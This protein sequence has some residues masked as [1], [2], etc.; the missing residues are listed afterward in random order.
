MKFAGE[1][2]RL[3]ASDVANFVACQHMTRLDL[4]EARGRLHRPRRFDVGFEDLVQRGEEHERI[5]LEQFRADGCQVVDMNPSPSAET[6]AAQATREAIRGGADVI[7]QGVLLGNSPDGGTALLGRPDFLV[8]ADLLAAP[9]GEPRQNKLHYEVVDAKLARTAKARAVAQ[10]AF[11]SHLLAELQGVRPRWMHLALGQ[12]ELVPL[13]VGDYAAYERQ[14]RRALSAFIAAD[15][16][17]NPPAD[18]YPEPVEH[19]V[20]CRWD[21]LC[22][23]RRRRDDDLSLV[24]GITKD[25]RRTLKASGVS[26][27][28]GLA[29]LAVLPG[30]TQAS[31]DS[32]AGARLQA[33]LQVA[34][35]DEARVRYELLDPE[36]DQAGAL[37]ANRGLLALPEPAVGDL[38][39]DIEGARY[40]S[41]DNR[42]FGLQYLFGVVDTADTDARG[43]PRYTQIWA[44]D[45][46]D[47]KR[48]FEELIDFITERRRRHPGLRV[49]HYNHYEPTSVD[50]LTELHGTRQEA[51]G[52]LMGR[53]A[54]REDEVDDLFRRGVF[55]DLYRVV[56]QGVRA[57][58]ESYSIKRLEPLCD[59][60]RQM[61]LRQATEH[62]IAFEAALDDQT[63][64]DAGDTKRV[65]AAYN[66]DDCRA[67]LALR[68]WLEQ[69]RAELAARLGADLPRP[70]AVAEPEVTENPELTRIR[71]A[72]LAGLPADGSARTE[73]QKARALLA[74]LLDW[75]RRDAKPEWWRYFYVRTLS[76]AEL[77]GEPDALGGLTGGDVVDQVKRSVVRRFSFPPQEYR[78]KRGDS[79]VDPA[80]NRSF[81]VWGVDDEHGTIDLKVGQ[82]YP[83]PW[84]A[85]LVE[86]DPVKTKVLAERLRD[87]GD[88]VV[89]EGVTGQHAGT[90]L[91][92]RL[93]PDGGGAAGP[94]R[95]DGEPVTDAA[96]RL[97]LALRG[98]YL[99]IQGPPGTGKTFTAALQILELIKA[100]R[101]VGI[102]GPSHAV[103]HN[104]IGE[105]TARADE[106]GVVRPRIGQRPGQ[107]TSYLHP[108]AVGL[109]LGALESGLR[110]GDL[111]VAA[112]TVWVWARE[113]FQGRVDTLFVDEAGQMP[114]ANILAVAG[115]ARNLVL[116]G[117]PQQL[118]QPSQAAHPPGAGVS[119]LEHILGDHATVPPDAGLFLDQTW[120][121]HP[122]LCRYTSET[123]YDGKL[124]WVDGLERQEVLGEEVLRGSGLGGSGL[125]VVEVTHEGNTN[126]SPEEAEVVARLVC[127]LMGRQWQDKDGVRR[128]IGADEVLVVTPY[129][130]QIRAIEDALARAGCSGGVMVGTVDKF[131]GREAPV[132]IY[133]MAT[134]SADD[135]PRGLEFLYDPH[136]LNVA[137]SRSRALAVVV[138]STDLIRVACRTPRQMYL[139]NALCRAWESA[140]T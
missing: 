36:R 82:A 12:G 117:D 106:L 44:F 37:L 121:M 99:P 138:A 70:A 64:R 61:D 108:D 10:T 26:T 20:I 62:L 69:L 72:L 23:D 83:G 125:Q 9:D 137:T 102:T 75:H 49:Y 84:P 111:D 33:R 123:F 60:T 28:R 110:D 88:R 63:A 67:T 21:D 89:R 56:R 38:F 80:A 14:A 128:V 42:E 136:R 105:V 29:S 68:D 13:K 19:C 25:Q 52:W 86:D 96:V 53:F 85:A 73:E 78:F 132:A 126:A 57:G 103:I 140:S 97:V 6:A 100:G 115:A 112:G 113:Q 134:S 95:G 41:E 3:S 43:R 39:F 11:Y 98:S 34:S 30:R 32:L 114:L 104:L 133:S 50:H 18:P 91:L 15:P 55:V 71:S 22:Q 107:D 109:E 81:L 129:N 139:A 16:G 58:V 48:A 101:T 90:A 87:L 5:V 120:R 124:T 31:R 122:R 17:R 119:A 59:Y 1:R 46:Q 130:A 131:Q 77:I 24:A 4:L 94:L 2:L 66:E 7:Y 92:L 65:V 40:Y 45:R 118:A 135:A 54:T 127:G 79:A 74:D 27:R 116:I 76:A 35:E 8:R 47:E 93:R 51:V